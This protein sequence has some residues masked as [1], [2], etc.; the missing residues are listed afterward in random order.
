MA[1]DDKK[2]ETVPVST[3][4]MDAAISLER[5]AISLERIADKFAPIANVVSMSGRSALKQCGAG[6]Q[7][8]PTD[9]Y[10]QEC[11]RQ[12]RNPKPVTGGDA[13]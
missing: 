8:Q 13:A 1:K 4:E 12:R 10:C 5:I 7:M 2:P 3:Y 11:M 9:D 6:H